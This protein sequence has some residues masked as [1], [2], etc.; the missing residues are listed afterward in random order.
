MTPKADFLLMRSFCY[1]DGIYN[2]QNDRV[3]TAN[4]EEADKEC[5]VHEKNKFPVKVMVWLDVCE[6]GLTEP[7]ILEDGT[8]SFGQKE[9]KNENDISRLKMLYS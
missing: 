5:G 4:R 1:L 9:F 7:L 2:T 3:W 6:Q 8:N